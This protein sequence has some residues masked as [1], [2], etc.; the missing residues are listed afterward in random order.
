MK[1]NQ[2]TEQIEILSQTQMVLPSQQTTP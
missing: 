1:F 2:R